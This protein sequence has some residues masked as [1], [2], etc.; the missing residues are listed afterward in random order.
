[1]ILD[2]NSRFSRK[3][4]REKT[5]HWR[6]RTTNTN[7]WRSC[8]ICSFLLLLLHIW[9]I[10]SERSFSNSWTSSL[11]RRNSTL[12]STH[13]TTPIDNQNSR[14]TIDRS[15]RKIGGVT[16]FFIELNRSFSFV[17]EQQ[18]ENEKLNR[19]KNRLTQDQEVRIQLTGRTA[20][21][22]FI[23][24]L[25][26]PNTRFRKR[27]SDGKSML[28]VDHLTFLFEFTSRKLTVLMLENNVIIIRVSLM[29]W[30]LG[31][32]NVMIPFR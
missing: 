17:Q 21:H 31:W 22:P 1:M 25:F 20:P 29:I 12:Q 2:S 15:W 26:H 10:Y 3:S 19:Q 16:V 6:S 13:W 11:E 30:K 28:I 27:I 18:L 5:F 32:N 4:R 24:G 7:I 8:F 9:L 23:L 14:T